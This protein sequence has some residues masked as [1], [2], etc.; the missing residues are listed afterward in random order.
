MGRRVSRG[1]GI[2][3]F[4]HSKTRESSDV[5]GIATLG[6]AQQLARTA[7]SVEQLAVLGCQ[8]LADGMRTHSRALR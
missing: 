3:S 2:S 8:F 1:A 5:N 6:M 7:T 4:F